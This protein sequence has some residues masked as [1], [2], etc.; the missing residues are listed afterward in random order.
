M[1]EE[2]QEEMQGEGGR[3]RQNQQTGKKRSRMRLRERN[4][5]DE[6][7]KKSALR[8]LLLPRRSADGCGG[9]NYRMIVSH[10]WMYIQKH[11]FT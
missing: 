1:K 7:K 6:K 4:T 2:R 9:R 10:T 5:R 8:L 11:T 3:L